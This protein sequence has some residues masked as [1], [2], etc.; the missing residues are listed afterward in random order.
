M[1]GKCTENAVRMYITVCSAYVAKMAPLKLVVQQN[2]GPYVLFM[3]LKSCSHV[4]N[5]DLIW[6]DYA[7]YM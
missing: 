1:H 5:T 4:H 3:Y 6:N 2:L 7:I